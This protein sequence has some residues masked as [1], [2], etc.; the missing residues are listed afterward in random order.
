METDLLLLSPWYKYCYIC[1]DSVDMD[2]FWDIKK[3][4]REGLV[5]F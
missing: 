5:E 4:V 2:T 1:Y 3:C